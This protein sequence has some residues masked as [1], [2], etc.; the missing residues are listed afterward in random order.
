[1]E[2]ILHA[3]QEEVQTKDLPGVIAPAI[4][5]HARA[6]RFAR[7]WHGLSAAL[8][9]META[10]ASTSFTDFKNDLTEDHTA[11]INYFKAAMITVIPSPSVFIAIALS[12]L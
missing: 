9:N 10:W 8:K 4:L 3:Q 7:G 5:N 12:F 6:Q 11:F 2:I 1:M